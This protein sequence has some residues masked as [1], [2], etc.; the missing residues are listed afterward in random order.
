MLPM[1][2]SHHRRAYPQYVRRLLDYRQMDLEYTL[3]QMFTTCVNPSKLCVCFVRNCVA[4][5]SLTRAQVPHNGV[6]QT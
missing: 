4:W 3:W 6:A 2:S 1:F 5:L